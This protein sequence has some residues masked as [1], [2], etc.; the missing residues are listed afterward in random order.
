MNIPTIT[1]E[2][3]SGD[4]ILA[5]GDFIHV[6]KGM[7]RGGIAEC[8]RQ[9]GL[10]KLRHGFQLTDLIEQ[11]CIKPGRTYNPHERWT[12]EELIN[13]DNPRKR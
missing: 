2:R 10:H 13:N 7:R 9:L 3:N 5:D 12:V 6:I 1:G 4:Y 11:V 8:R